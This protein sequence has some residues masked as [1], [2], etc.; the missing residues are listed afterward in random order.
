MK[1]DGLIAIFA[2]TVLIGL[3]TAFA[4]ATPA[5]ARAEA[6]AV[7]KF[8]LGV[9]A[10]ERQDLRDAVEWF[11][12]SFDLV[13]DAATAYFLSVSFAR[14]RDIDGA[15][16]DTQPVRSRTGGSTFKN[17]PDARA[18]ELVDAA[19]CRGLRIGGGPGPPGPALRPHG[20]EP[21]PCPSGPVVSAPNP[22][23]F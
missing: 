10:F 11:R 23:Q 16:K 15:R 9:S 1:P 14:M 21:R 12:D 20:R 3:V 18:W 2:G 7:E 22:A 6:E 4:G 19:G 17:P 8:N 13:P 5:A